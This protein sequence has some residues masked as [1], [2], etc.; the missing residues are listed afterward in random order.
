MD[1]VTIIYP[2]IPPSAPVF[3]STTNQDSQWSR[4]V[5]PLLDWI[6]PADTPAPLFAYYYAINALVVDAGALTASANIMSKTVTGTALPSLSEGRHEYQIVSQGDPLSYPLSSVSVFHVWKDTLAPH[7]PVIT[8]PTHPTVDESGNDSPAYNLSADDEDS[9]TD[10]VS[11]VAGYRY[12]LDHSAATI[13][14]AS[15]PFTTASSVSYSGLADGMWWFHARTVD[16]AGSPSGASH[17]PVNIS[18]KNK[19]RIIIKSPTH[20]ENAESESNNP[21]FSLSVSNPESATL[22][23][24][25]YALDEHPDTSPGASSSHTVQTTL[26]F[27]G[28]R[29]Q[30]WY[31]HVNTRNSSSTFSN[32]AHYGFRVNFQGK[33]LE[34]SD[35]HAVPHPIRGGKAVIRYYLQAPTQ[36]FTAEVLDGNGRRVA[37]LS[38][39]TAPGTNE[40]VWDTSGFA[41]GVYFLRIKVRK[42]DGKTETVI[43]KL[44]V[45]R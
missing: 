11:G 40:M 36:E 29:N 7:P 9:A 17:Y 44:A 1:S 27:S 41:N 8:S 13:P 12:V 3:S 2:G 35:V 34:E 31:L 33:I 23:G 25:Y 20:P 22:T 24:F 43:K 28:L 26:K 4:I 19:V 10:M 30:Q 14:S 38:G 18:F 45:V 39:S 15:D 16:G 42:Q 6:E 21:E 37:R 32:T 5:T